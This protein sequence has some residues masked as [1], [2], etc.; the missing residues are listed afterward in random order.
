MPIPHLC[1]LVLNQYLD[2]LVYPNAEIRTLCAR[3]PSSM[4]FTRPRKL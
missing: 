1:N 2:A 4:P 3:H